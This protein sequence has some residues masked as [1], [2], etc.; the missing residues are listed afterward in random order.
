ME[1]YP[2]CQ[3]GTALRG[4]FSGGKRKNSIFYFSGTGK[5]LT[6]SGG[7]LFSPYK[8]GSGLSRPLGFSLVLS[9]LAYSAK[10]KY[11]CVYALFNFF[12][13]L[14]KLSAFL[15]TYSIQE[16]NSKTV[17][18]TANCLHWKA[19][20]YLANYNLI[21]RLCLYW[22][23][24]RILHTHTVAGM[25]PCQVMEKVCWVFCLC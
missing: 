9:H 14:L 25:V 2:S 13:F 20:L 5:A 1:S 19:L 3:R 8:Q 24:P 10:S 15:W 21:G 16:R 12:F 18:I 4:K 11:V 7:L 23:L 22:D 6:V 17:W